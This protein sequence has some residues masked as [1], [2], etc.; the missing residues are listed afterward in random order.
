MKKLIMR[1]GSYLQE[2]QLHQVW[3][4]PHDNKS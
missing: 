2:K 4:N 1:G 3:T